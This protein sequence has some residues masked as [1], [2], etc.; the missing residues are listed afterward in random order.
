MKGNK[1]PVLIAGGTGIASLSFL[2]E[3]LKV[4]GIIFTGSRTKKEL[5]GLDR[6][7]KLGWQVETATDDGSAGFKG[8]VTDLCGGPLA[9]MACRETVMFCCGPRGML[10]RCA[11]LAKKYNIEGY[12]SLEEMM[13][14]GTGCC[15]G[16]AVK[17]SGEYKRACSDGPVF[18]LGDIDE[19]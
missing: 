2:A 10:K 16:C 14:C 17:I 1:V 13:A 7:R 5:V 8:F 18:R 9:K 3:R 19:D 6:F 15:Q 11:A 12:A 4:E